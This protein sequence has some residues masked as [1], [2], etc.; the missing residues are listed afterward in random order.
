M[1]RSLKGTTKKPNDKKVGTLLT[2]Y[3]VSREKAESQLEKLQSKG[4]PKEP[5]TGQQIEQLSAIKRPTLLADEEAIM[6]KKRKRL[7][8]DRLRS[9]RLSTIL[10]DTLG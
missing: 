7:S 3:D 5:D 1:A 9:G 8:A 10:D 4:L 2:E 6:K